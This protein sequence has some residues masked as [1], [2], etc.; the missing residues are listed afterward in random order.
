MAL[1][2][3]IQFGKKKKNRHT[4]LIPKHPSQYMWEHLAYYII[5]SSADMTI[6]VAHSQCFLLSAGSLIFV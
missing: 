6:Q 1:E 4:I 3:S 2:L 5:I